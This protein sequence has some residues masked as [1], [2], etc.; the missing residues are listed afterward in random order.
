MLKNKDLLHKGKDMEI[1]FMSKKENDRLIITL[2]VTPE[3]DI[4]SLSW[5]V[6]YDDG[7]IVES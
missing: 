7:L 5:T 3:R 1:G 4:E 6:H 2:Y